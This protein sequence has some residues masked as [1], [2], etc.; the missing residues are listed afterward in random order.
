MIRKFGIP[1]FV[2]VLLAVTVPLFQLINSQT[3]TITQ[4]RVVYELPYPGILPDHPLY[5]LK[6]WRD[7]GLEITT[8]DDVNKAE[9]YIHLS[10]KYIN[11]GSYIMKKGKT[12]QGKEMVKMA[13]VYAQKIPSILKRLKTQGSGPT[14]QLVDKV[15]QSNVKHREVIQQMMKQISQGDQKGLEEALKINEKVKKELSGF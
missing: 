7:K 4:E 12:S 6:T 8:R 14:Q 9:L 11:T 15:R 2:F 3:I 5:F 10:D 1:L 13:E